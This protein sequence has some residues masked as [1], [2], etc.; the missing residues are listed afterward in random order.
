[1][2]RPCPRACPPTRSAS[3]C[4]K[5]SSRLPD[6]LW[7]TY[8]STFWSERGRGLSSQ[9]FDGRQLDPDVIAFHLHRKR[10]NRSQ[11][12]AEAR[13]TLQVEGILVQRTSHL[14]YASSIAKNSCL[15]YTS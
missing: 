7:L 1:M 15:L 12:S 5:T 11:I 9:L 13:A 8:G 3:V 14:G 4:A 2:E 10:R 6:R